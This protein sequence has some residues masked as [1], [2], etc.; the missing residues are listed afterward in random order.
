MRKNLPGADTGAC[1]LK[2][3]IP[4]RKQQQS[5]GTSVAMCGDLEAATHHALSGLPEST[6]LRSMQDS[7]EA[8]PTLLKR[9]RGGGGT[10]SKDRADRGAE[11][12]IKAHDGGT[13]GNGGTNNGGTQG[14]GGTK[15]VIRTHD[16]GTEGRT[17]GGVN[18]AGTNG[19]SA[20]GGADGGTRVGATKEGASNGGIAE[21][22]INGGANKGT[23]EGT[24]G[25]TNEGTNGGTQGGTNKGTQGG[26]DG[27]TQ[28]GTKGQTDEGTEDGGGT[29]SNSEW[30]PDEAAVEQTASSHASKSPASKA[31]AGNDCSFS[32]LSAI[33]EDNDG[34]EPVQNFV[35]PA[36]DICVPL[37]TPD[38]VAFD[39]RQVH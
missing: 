28:G 21:G 13:K 1:L 12:A 22:R 16:R 27:G 35:F 11:D 19:E 36:H 33:G 39:L 2:P 38:V 29:N 31:R 30:L 24:Q 10:A 25:G 7:V 32:R 34:S 4:G 17:D 37:S 23:D 20:E 9:I 5:M 3:D 8:C 6:E 26:T 14:S 15:D 18:D